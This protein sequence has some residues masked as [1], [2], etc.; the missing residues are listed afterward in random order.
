MTAIQAL[1]LGQDANSPCGVFNGQ[2]CQM[3]LSSDPLH[4]IMERLSNPGMCTACSLD[5]VFSAVSKSKNRIMVG[6]GYFRSNF[7]ESP[8]SK[9]ELAI[10]LC[11]FG[12]LLVLLILRVF[13]LLILV[14]R[15]QEACNC[16]SW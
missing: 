5:D 8:N 16:G 10:E 3:C 14:L 13:L 1:Q 15:R 7:S 9:N 4:K 2:R 12:F 6:L 11:Y